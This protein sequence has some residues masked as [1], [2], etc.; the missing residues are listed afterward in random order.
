MTV[1]LGKNITL[2]DLASLAGQANAL[3]KL[4]KLVQP[5]NPNYSAVTADP[6][7]VW[8]FPEA[9]GNYAAGQGISHSDLSGHAT[10][11][12]QVTVAAVDENGGLLGVRITSLGDPTGDSP[13]TFPGGAVFSA[14]PVTVSA[15]RNY[16]FTLDSLNVGW[17][18]TLV[19][20]KSNGGYHAGDA[21]LLPE[22]NNFP[23]IVDA[24]DGDGKIQSYSFPNTGEFG[25]RAIPDNITNLPATGGHGAG[26]VFAGLFVLPPRPAW[27]TELERL[28]G[29]LTEFINNKY[30]QSGAQGL[31]VNAPQLS[32]SGPW[33]IA[34]PQWYYHDQWFWYEDTGKQENVTVQCAMYRGAVSYG[35][36]TMRC[37]QVLNSYWGLDPAPGENVTNL[38]PW[39]WYADIPSN[40]HELV[41]YKEWRIIIGGNQPVTLSGKFYIW[42]PIIYGSTK[43]TYQRFNGGGY[44]TDVVTETLDSTNP[45][46]MVSDAGSNFPGT[47]RKLVMTTSQ[48]GDFNSWAQIGG[49]WTSPI[50]AGR[51]AHEYL[52]LEWDVEGVEVKPG[53]YDIKMNFLQ[54]TTP[55][56]VRVGEPSGNLDNLAPGGFPYTYTVTHTMLVGLTNWEGEGNIVSVLNNTPSQANGG[57]WYE[58]NGNGTYSLHWGNQGNYGA[59]MNIVL[60]D[61]VPADG[62]DGVKDLKKI[63]LPDVAVNDGIDGTV[64]LP[65]G[66]YVVRVPVYASVEHGDLFSGIDSGT[67]LIDGA[68]WTPVFS[69][70][71]IQIAGTWAVTTSVEGMWSGVTPPIGDLN[72]VKP[73]E[74][75]WNLPRTYGRVFNVQSDSVGG[76]TQTGVYQYTANPMLLG[77]L[78]PDNICPSNG[79]DQGAPVENQSEP[80]S[81]KPFTW[82]TEG[83][84]IV[85]PSIGGP[86]D[87]KGA[88]LFVCSR[89]GYSGKYSPAFAYGMASPTDYQYM[90]AGMELEETLAPSEMAEAFPDL[91]SHGAKPYTNQGARWKCIKVWRPNSTWYALPGSI[92]LGDTCIDYNGN[93]QI[94]VDS[95][96]PR[97]SYKLY[98]GALEFGKNVLIDVNGNL[99]LCI[100]AGNSGATPPDW[101]KNAVGG[102]DAPGENGHTYDGTVIWENHGPQARETLQTRMPYQPLVYMPPVWNTRLGGLTQDLMVT[103][104]MIKSDKDRN[105]RRFACRHRELNNGGF[106]SDGVAWARDAVPR[107]PVYWLDE[108]LASQKPPPTV[109]P[110]HG[111]L[112]SER[113][114]W[115]CGSQWQRSFGN[116]QPDRYNP[117]DKGW[118]YDNLARAWWICSVTVHRINQAGSVSVTIGC[119]RNGSFVAFGTYPTGGTYRVQWPVFTSDALVYQCS[120]RVNV[121]AVAQHGAWAGQ[122]TGQSPDGIRAGLGNVNWPIA[123]DYVT[124]VQALLSRL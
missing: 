85:T 101:N 89:A 83:F 37:L 6:A 71:Q 49:Q 7:S 86:Q 70:S 104:K 113:T 122:W 100:Q 55:N 94:A 87:Y 60:T 36:Y 5:G 74:M 9:R 3:G 2:D 24:V 28:R 18:K 34:A 20:L 23:V 53:A 98:A 29:N 117:Y 62:I 61:S 65:P 75:P 91:D 118:Q 63:Q 12:L 10:G 40:Y 84:V 17:L 38:T 14:T 41:T 124:D 64:K 1:A 67:A 19:C 80:S 78:N 32:V 73:A 81:W 16:A 76:A 31:G 97:T 4:P 112:D 88:A 123:A 27:K 103:W 43:T 51:S 116:P 44:P 56:T 90:V 58:S 115:G 106:S 21:L 48:G 102:A 15:T 111:G 52:V 109:L 25:Y 108:P 46:D 30:N 95:W 35:R 11:W 66:I 50:P 119:M 120:E 82:F 79:Y 39:K 33:P 110:N 69:G 42:I 59:S 105:F 72:L 99:Q 8:I 13:S 107:Y 93:T 22:F 47:F 114:I 26:A 92:N 121:H 57:Y 68:G 96:Q 54:P 45:V 77:N